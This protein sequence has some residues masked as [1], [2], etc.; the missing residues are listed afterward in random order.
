MPCLFLGT[1]VKVA[2]AKLLPSFS[3]MAFL[4]SVVKTNP[5]I[6]LPPILIHSVPPLHWWLTSCVLSFNFTM[7]DVLTNSF[8][9]ILITCPNHLSVPN[10]THSTTPQSFPFIVAPIP[11][12]SHNFSWLP[13][14][15]LVDI[16]IQVP[17]FTY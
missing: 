12:L 10:L 1:F 13:S 6:S 5:V 3:V 9:L 15:L 8:S 4:H 16:Y 7:H 11:K 14:S 17:L 2:K